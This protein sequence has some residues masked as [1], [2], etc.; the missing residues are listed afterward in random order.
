MGCFFGLLASITSRN[1]K[2]RDKG[3]VAKS[4][5]DKKTVSGK[6]T[7]TGINKD[8]SIKSELKNETGTNDEMK[9]QT[10]IKKIYIR[11]VKT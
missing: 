4:G 6:N 8:R 3:E 11:Y 1:S 10:D 9:S 5:A 7:Q 2:E